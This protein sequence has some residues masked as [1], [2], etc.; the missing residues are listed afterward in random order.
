MGN[1]V[2]VEMRLLSA[3][4]RGRAD[5]VSKWLGAGAR[6]AERDGEGMTALMLAARGGLGGFECRMQWRSLKNAGWRFIR[7]GG[8]RRRG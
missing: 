6:V 1:G 7:C 3:A 5:F 4:A 8:A 2:T